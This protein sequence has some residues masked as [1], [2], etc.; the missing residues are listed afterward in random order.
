MKDSIFFAVLAGGLFSSLFVIPLGRIW[1]L[2]ACC[3]M[4]AV[5]LSRLR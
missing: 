1:F 4:L 5:G 3:C 2:A